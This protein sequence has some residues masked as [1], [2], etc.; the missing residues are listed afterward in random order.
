MKQL[1]ASTHTQIK[2]LFYTMGHVDV[3][4]FSQNEPMEFYSL[5]IFFIALIKAQYFDNE[6]DMYFQPFL[7][8]FRIRFQHF[9]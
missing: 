2:C 4:S 7:E 6:L 5:F 3:L 8:F 1:K 9:E